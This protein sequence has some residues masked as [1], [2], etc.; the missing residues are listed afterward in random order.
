MANEITSLGLTLAFNGNTIGE[1]RSLSGARSAEIHNIASVDS[2][3]NTIEKLAG[4]IDEGDVS[5]NIIYDGSA[6]GV[7]N[8]LNTDFKA[9]TKGTLLITHSDGSTMSCSAYISSLGEPSFGAP[10]EPVAVDV[11]FSCEAKTYTDV[12]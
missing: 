7:Y 12:A 10:G 8:D 2:A 5:V 3:N 1:I 4:L 9:R 6:A 11:T